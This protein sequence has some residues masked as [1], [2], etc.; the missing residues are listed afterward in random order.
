M[1]LK[2]RANPAQIVLTDIPVG[3]YIK[4]TNSKGDKMNRL[5][6]TFKYPATELLKAVK[7]NREK[8]VAD[9][10]EAFIN[11]RKLLKTEL[12]DLVARVEKGGEIDHNIRLRKPESHER[13]YD[14]AIRMLE[15]TGDREI[16]LDG[17]TFAKLVMDEW[18]WQQSFTTNTKSYGEAALALMGSASVRY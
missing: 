5:H 12:S 14:Q 3:A 1:E 15:M 9:Y 4:R 11:Y 8:H 2:S 17:Q 6:N 16:E 7:E 18:E 10:K 13:E